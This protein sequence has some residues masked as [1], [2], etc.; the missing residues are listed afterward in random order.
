MRTTF[1]LLKDCRKK[2]TRAYLNHRR[3]YVNTLNN[4]EEKT[5]ETSKIKENKYE[6]SA[7]TQPKFE[8]D[9]N[10]Y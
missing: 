5:Q 1:S 3:F 4:Q 2:N 7:C 6:L 10:L 9:N 8:K